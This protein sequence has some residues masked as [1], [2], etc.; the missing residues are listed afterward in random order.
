MKTMLK[1]KVSLVM[2]VMMV[3]GML[4][5]CGMK[6]DDAKAYVQ[7][8]LD[9][10]YKA[11]FGEYAKITD[12]TEEEAQKLFDDNINKTINSLGF[13]ALGATEETMDKYRE[14]LKEI[15]S[16]AKYTVGDVKEADGGFEVEVTAEPM[17]IFSGMQDELVAKMQEKATK[18]NEQLSE[19]KINQLAIDLVHELLTEKLAKVTY[20]E[21]KTITVH[22][23]KN[24]DGVWNITE[25]DLQTVD[26]SLFTI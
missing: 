8:T 18:S 1:R 24:S 3:L 15:S 16:K 23:T 21:P 25:S 7:A 10:S 17:E 5:G 26:T 22:V 6:P 2:V 9:A 4:T 20:G 19:D 13:D 11:E 12:S 14:L